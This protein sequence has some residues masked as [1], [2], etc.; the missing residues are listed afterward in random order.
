MN[1]W[2]WILVGVVVNGC[3]LAL[4]IA[5]A[6]TTDVEIALGA[7]CCAV[8]AVVLGAAVVDQATR[9]SR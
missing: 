4:G 2:S 5:A 9:G 3:A 8:A 6:F 1:P 7:L